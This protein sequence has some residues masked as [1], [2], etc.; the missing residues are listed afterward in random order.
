MCGGLY[1]GLTDRDFV[2]ARSGINVKLIK[3]ILDYI[4]VCEAV[5][6]SNGAIAGIDRQSVV[7]IYS[8]TT[9]R[10]VVADADAIS[11]SQ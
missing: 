7:E 6:E 1:N 3:G 11:E 9:I 8:I 10:I 4:T 5:A 2:V